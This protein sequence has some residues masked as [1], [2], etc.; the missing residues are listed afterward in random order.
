MHN[1]KDRPI[2]EA[3]L[4][5]GEVVTDILMRGDILAEIP[6][7]GTA[8]K[9]C[10]AADAIRDRAFAI[11]LS[12]FV[13]N[14]EGISE[15]QKKKLKEKMNA[16]AEEAQK[17]G[18]TLLFVLER[19]TDL[20]KPSLLA[21]IFLAYIDGIVS[22]EELRRLCQAVDTAFAGDL[23]QLFASDKTL[24]KSEEPWML[25][26]VASGLTRLIGGEDVFDP[27]RLYCQVTPLGQKL[28]SACCH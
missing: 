6:L 8:I 1:S 25:Y 4:E 3:T 7:I 28:K 11:K 16:S 20:D 21:Q 12:R 9:I 17:V 13:Q 27:G 2:V 24:E 22:G 14:F 10:K 19:V 18:E 5:S 15:E 23:Q 26:L